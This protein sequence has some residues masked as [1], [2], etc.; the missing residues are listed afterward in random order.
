MESEIQ[1]QN[2]PKLSPKELE[3]QYRSNP[4][5]FRSSFDH[6]AA[7]IKDEKLLEFW[8]IR[9]DYESPAEVPLQLGN[10]RQI[11]ALVFVGSL[12]LVLI[13]IPEIF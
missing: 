5:G 10:T 9:L 6:I 11:S 3:Q 12:M 2:S 8:K 7:K 4:K 13:K 1:K